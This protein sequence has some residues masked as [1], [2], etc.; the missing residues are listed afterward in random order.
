MGRAESSIDFCM[1]RLNHPEIVEA[2][3]DAHQR[4]VNVRVVTDEDYW[5]VSYAGSYRE[6][7][8][9]GIE[10]RVDV[11]P[12]TTVMHHKFVVFDDQAVWTGD[13]N[14]HLNDSKSFH[15]AL[16]IPLEELARQ[17]VT[18]FDELWEGRVA[19][20]RSN[21][22]ATKAVR[23]K[24]GSGVS[25]VHPYFPPGELG[26]VLMRRAIADAHQTIKI[27]H[28]YMFSRV[29]YTELIRAAERGVH[30]E[31]LYEA[32]SPGVAGSLTLSGA[33]IRE[34]TRFVGCKYVIIDSDRLLVG[35]WNAGS[36]GTD[37][38]NLI[39]VTGDRMLCESFEEYFDSMMSLAQPFADAEQRTAII[40]VSPTANF[41]DLVTLAELDPHAPRASGLHVEIGEKST[42]VSV[43]VLAGEVGEHQADYLLAMYFAKTLQKNGAPIDRGC[44][45]VVLSS[46][47]FASA[48][49]GDLVVRFDLSN[50]P[51]KNMNVYVRVL[52]FDPVTGSR[53]VVGSYA[54][55]VDAAVD[56]K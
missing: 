34:G 51:A 24:A 9:A 19:D 56:P 29:V 37:I 30:V 4:G 43:R 40:P 55:R 46:E 35:S 1:F 42:T 8:D 17:Y 16:Y 25:T 22:L 3:I 23:Y 48:G 47:S 45:P 27:A 10:V 32:T 49:G 39:E 18:A 44:M 26:S 38:E 33:D 12:V 21:A 11:S 20:T 7:I 53:R 15:T 54:N 31:I 5:A 13:W 41:S 2:L 52:R 14:A 28:S 6:L 50:K 36:S